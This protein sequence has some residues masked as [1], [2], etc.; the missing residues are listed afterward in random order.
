MLYV[1]KYLN[2]HST[3]QRSSSK[4]D[5]CTPSKT[6]QIPNRLAESSHFSQDATA[7][8]FHEVNILHDALPLPLAFSTFATSKTQT[9]L[10]RLM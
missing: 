3:A 8:S 2:L 10:P 4:K 5:T 1:F 6:L 9:Q 7:L